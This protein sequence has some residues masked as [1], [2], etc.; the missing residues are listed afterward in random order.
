LLHLLPLLLQLAVPHLLPL[1]KPL[2]KRRRKKT[3][4]A[5]SKV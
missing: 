2:L 5:D 1:R 4:V 3:T